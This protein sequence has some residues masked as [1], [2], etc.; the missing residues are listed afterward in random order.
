MRIENAWLT[1][2]IPTILPY[3]ITQRMLPASTLPLEYKYQ[4]GSCIRQYRFKVVYLTDMFTSEKFT[5]EKSPKSQ[6][7]PSLI[8]LPRFTR[9]VPSKPVKRWN[10]RKARWSHYITLTNE[11]ARTFPPPDLPHMDQAYQCFCNAI[12]TAAKKCISRGR[13]NNCI[14][15][16][17]AEF[18]NLYQTFL[19]YLE[20]H[21][22]SRAATALLARLDRK[23]RD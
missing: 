1:G 16:W 7:R 10:L 19:K 18:E 23:R 17:D 8:T 12:S 14:Q 6:L 5:S 2:Q 22:S 15:C 3:S 11:L 9:P 20:G 21:E 4:P 13:Q